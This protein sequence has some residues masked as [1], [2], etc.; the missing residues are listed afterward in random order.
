MGPQRLKQ[1]A[2]HPEINTVVGGQVGSN[3]TAPARILIGP[4]V[5]LVVIAA[6]EFIDALPKR[7]GV[8]F[9]TLLALVAAASF[10]GALTSGLITAS[11]VIAYAAFFCFEAQ[12]V[13]G[14]VQH[15][16]A[17]TVSALAVGVTVGLL[18]KWS[19]L[20]HD[21]RRARLQIGKEKEELRELV[22]HVQAIVWEADVEPLRF[23]F[24]SQKARELLG[25]PVEDW[26]RNSSFWESHIHPSDRDSTIAALQQA[27]ATG[28][29]HELIYRMLRQDG[30]PVWLSH[31]LEVVRGPSGKAV[32]LRGRIVDVTRQ[33][34][35]ERRLAAV[36]AAS[37]ALMEV[38]SLDEAGHGVLEGICTNLEWKVGALW[39][40]DADDRLLRCAAVWNGPNGGMDEFIQETLRAPMEEGTGLP[41]RTWKSGRPLWVSDV[42]NDPKFTRADAARAADLH[43]AFA[44]PIRSANEFL[45]VME[46][47]N[48]EI[49]EPDDELLQLMDS[50]GIQV[51]QRIIRMR[52]EHAVREKVA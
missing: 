6:F 35:A 29:G 1:Q 41:G 26:L 44:V 4:A 3:K 48:N 51:G 10:L 47:F 27:V 18:R 28:D 23:T 7:E 34:D 49:E 24:V 33:K 32:K 52:T 8:I 46:F 9:A 38:D 2:T 31:A 30:R 22:D 45:G 43:G 14:P 19:I 36:H 50:V 15:F 37:K 21:E 20:Y 12:R 13:D 16:V 25:Y 39:V 17:L 40:L 42:L 11:L 5:A